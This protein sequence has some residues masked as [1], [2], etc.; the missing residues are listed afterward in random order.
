MKN[1]YDLSEL[2]WTVEGY[3]PYVWLF[4]RLYANPFNGVKCVDIPPIP[5]RVPGSVQG[6]LR[7]EIG[8]AH[9]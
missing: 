6:A 7:A 1:Q 3:T 4:D 8:R 5:A 2:S 9:V